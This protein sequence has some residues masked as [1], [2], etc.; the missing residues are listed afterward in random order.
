M[1]IR[2]WI[3]FLL[4][5]CFLSGCVSSCD[6]ST[7]EPFETPTRVP[8]SVDAIN[9]P[10]WPPLGP[11]TELTVDVSDDQGLLGV[12]FTF[13]Q[14]VSVGVV[15]T[16]D[17]ASVTGAELGEGM[18]TLFVDVSDDEGNWATREVT[19]LLVDLSPPTAEIG[20]T[21]L[22]AK[23]GQIEVWAGDAWVLGSVE[24]QFQGKSRKHVFPEVYPETLGK[25]WDH[26]LEIFDAADF[27]AGQ[28]TA[29]VTVSDAAGN[30]TTTT[31]E[32]TLDGTPP[33]VA[34]LS[35]SAGS[36]VTG[37]FDVEVEAADDLGD[38]LIELYVGGSKVTTVLG[39]KATITLDTADFP[40]GPIA[41]E[42]I[43][44]DAAGNESAVAMAQIVIQ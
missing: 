44:I 6:F 1:I 10:T 22:R 34:L 31:F 21:L 36:E 23:G 28:G 4:L 26:S 40:P 17:T 39:P 9:V 24:L 15:G 25:E 33:S 5:S 42:A 38:A 41:L 8:P 14:F 13:A 3:F 18:G 12:N 32:L 37:A 2:T 35:P 30:K 11:S 43:A 29:T 20:A 19:D 27:P 7:R 16:E